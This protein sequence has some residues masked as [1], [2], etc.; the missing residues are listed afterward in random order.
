MQ[1][2][3][4]E[5]AAWRLA[6][7]LVRW[8]PTWRVIAGYVGDGPQEALCLIDVDTATEVLQI[9][10]RTAVR[11]PSGD[12][13]APCPTLD[14]SVVW[15]TLAS[16]GGVGLVTNTIHEHLGVTPPKRH[17]QS[18]PEGIGY[19]VIGAVLTADAANAKPMMAFNGRRG[20][21]PRDSH[22]R[23][24][25]ETAAYRPK[26]V[27]MLVRDG[28][29]VAHFAGGFVWTASGE[30]L[31][32]ADRRARGHSIATL[33]AAVND[34]AQPTR[35]GRIP[36]GDGFIEVPPVDDI[37]VLNEFAHTYDGYELLARD[38]HRLYD[39]VGPILEVV[40]RGGRVPDHVGLDMARGALFYLAREAHHVGWLTENDLPVWVPIVQHIR[41]LS[42]GRVAVLYPPRH[43]S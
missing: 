40:K 23:A 14:T 38:P 18:T 32:L 9:D 4:T 8:H 3:Q 13:A 34:G 2:R 7:E 42:G 19:R 27:W 22:L 43:A 1:L 17:P 6:A 11:F 16:P 15:E 25:P 33:A 41:A 37:N 26:Q 29:V 20:E 10:P 12:G 24:R 21:K 35:R 39:Q 28:T 31:N 36:G 30:R 5:A